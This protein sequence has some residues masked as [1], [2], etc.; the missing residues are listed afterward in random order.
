[1]NLT[2][3][4]VRLLVVDYKGCFRFYRDILGFKPGWGDEDSGYADFQAGGVKLALFSR[5]AMARAVGAEKWPAET[6]SQ[7]RVA[8]I[9]RVDDLDETYRRL[10]RGVAFGAEPQDRPDWGVRVAHFRD[11]DGNLIEV[12]QDLPGRP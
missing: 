9:F 7:D 10:D 1:M 2:L 12:N 4:H 6:P 3:T 8:L 5:E 11:P